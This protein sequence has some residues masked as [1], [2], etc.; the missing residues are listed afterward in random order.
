VLLVF[1]A[2]EK[3]TFPPSDINEDSVFYR[4][5]LLENSIQVIMQ[6]PF[7]G[8]F[9]FYYS[10]LMQDM[11]QGEGIIDVVNTYLGVGL[12]RGLVG[13]CLFSGFFIAAAIGI[14]NGMRRLTDRNGELY[15]LGQALF[16]SLVG[17]LVIIF[18]TSS[19][20]IIPV[21]YWSVAGLGVAYARMLALAKAPE[22]VRPTQFR[23]AA[24][25]I[26]T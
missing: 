10:P 18:T 23:P 16:S 7:F 24:L 25:K 20:S 3:L 15:L 1:P 13:L 5:R 6:N 21:I 9:D 2:A 22:V 26:R 19:V 8:N 11:R 14:F 4:Q 17:I 12:A